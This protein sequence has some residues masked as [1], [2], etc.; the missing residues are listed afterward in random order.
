[1]KIFSAIPQSAMA[2]LILGVATPF[3]PAQDS[4]SQKVLHATAYNS[5]F[6][7]AAKPGE[8]FN[9]MGVSSDGTIYYVLSSA[10]YNI[11]GQMYSL[12]PKTRAVTHIANLNQATGQEDIKAVAQGKS[13]VNF[14]EDSGKL[15]FSTHLG[16]YN[17]S[18]GVERTAVAPAGYLPYPGGHFLSY[19]LH[20]RK[21]AN[22]AI[23][24]GGQGIIAMNMDVRRGRLY[25]ITWP[26]GDFL[27][28]DLATRKLKDLGTV[29]HGG[30]L[31]ALGTTY[32]AICRRIVIDPRD[33]SA[34]FTAG[35]GTIHRYRYNAQKLETVPATNLK[36]DYFGSMNPALHGMG[37]NWRAAI[38]V[39]SQHA[40]YG[41]NGRSGYLFRFD[42]SKPSV[43][44][45]DRL[46]SEPS[47][48]SGMFDR[49][50][51]GYLGLALAADGHTLYYLTGAPLSA[52]EKRNK[53]PDQKEGTHLV[54]YDTATGKYLDHGSVVLQNG[55]P[56][57][58]PQSLVIGHDG[59]VYTLSFVVEDGKSGIELISLR[60]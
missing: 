17:R 33:G 18:S 50:E 49:A 32:R 39:P 44:V 42:P 60:P 38:W 21:F 2:I 51:Y 29:F 31:G 13:H 45:L 46:T 59:T 40:I 52:Q 8:A 34:Y 9:G 12:D 25:G 23:A 36:R 3:L 4:G 19:D 57:D 53:V 41:V 35:D 28:Y 37:Y 27:T 14:V 48:K 26:A 47:K 6:P 55:E 56:I 22:L 15:Y 11:P 16:Y 1:M 58:A 5:H 30:E 7:A 20:T 10:E 24:P 54:T 43:E